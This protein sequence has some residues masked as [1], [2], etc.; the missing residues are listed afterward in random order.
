M[1]LLNRMFAIALMLL[2]G[3]SAARAITGD[4]AEFRKLADDVY[5]YVGKL[6]DANAMV[7]VTSQGVIL[8]DTGNNQPDTRD[9]AEKIKSVTDQPVRWIVITQNHGDHF[10]GSPYFQPGATLLVHDRVARDLAA[11][12]PFQ[13]KSWRKRFPERTAALEKLKPSDMMMSFSD[14]MT[15]NLGGRRIELLYVDDTY[16]PGDVAVWL[17]DSGVMHASFAGY[18]D[19]HPDIRPDYSH[20]TTVGMLK[21][22]EAYLALK[23]RVVVPAHGPIGDVRDLQAMVDYLLLGRQKVRVMM[24][25][26]MDLPAIIK[27]FHMN[28]FKG[29]DRGSHFEWM[30]ETI[31]RELLGQGPQKVELVEASARGTLGDIKEEGRYFGFKTEDGKELRLRVA[32][33]TNI[34]GVADRTKLR[35]G[36]K[37]TASYLIPKNFNPALGFDIM[38][39]T[40][41]P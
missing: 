15:L 16:N 18:K 20:G 13:I 30:A 10:G 8:V 11:M 33:D 41:T 12:Q 31:H 24:E 21:Q 28:E 23:P 40:V 4:K 14:K 3:T 17:P 5:A 38:E 39:I 37:G 29:W 6:N 22:L 19:R 32:S 7:V 25:K 27:D 1:R 34:E 35:T 2:A 36:M 26:G 9:I